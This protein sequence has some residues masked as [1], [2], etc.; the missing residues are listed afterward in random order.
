MSI[1]IAGVASCLVSILMASFCSYKR[2]F[3]NFG[4]TVILDEATLLGGF[5]GGLDGKE[6]TCNVG[7]LSSIP[8]L[9]RS[10]EEGTPVFLSGESPWTEQPSRLQLMGPQ[11]IRHD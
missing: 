7:D 8:G 2:E 6:S 9:G 4:T 3:L 11:K 1:Y 10:L 5:P